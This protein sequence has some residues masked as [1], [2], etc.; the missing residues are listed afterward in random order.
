MFE[1]LVDS[2]DVEVYNR[3]VEMLKDTWSKLDADRGKVFHQW[4]MK[5]E[6][7]I[8]KDTMLKPIR[9]KAGFGSPPL[10]FSTNASECVNEILK[11]K[12]D[13]KHSKL[14]VFIQKLKQPVYLTKGRSSKEQLS[15]RE[16]SD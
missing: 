10:Q 7:H 16:I 2:V 14:P 1:G 6:Y 3:K 13:Y 9:E 15:T 5:Y 11:Q 8:I 12:V 4:F